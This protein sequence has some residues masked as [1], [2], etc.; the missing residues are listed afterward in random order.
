MDTLRY[1]LSTVL[2]VSVPPA[3][4]FWLVG[5]QLVALLRKLGLLMSYTLLGGVA[6]L[7]VLPLL[8]LRAVLVGADLGQSR[9]LAGLGVLLWIGSMYLE[10][11]CR[12]Y[13]TIKTLVGVPEFS[14]NPTN[15]PLIIEGIYGRMRHPRYASVMLG[16]FA[17]AFWANFV[18]PY[19]LAVL[20]VPMLYLVTL[21]EERE[22]VD[23]FGSAYVTYQGRVPRFIPNWR[24]RG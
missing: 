13:L 11:R 23:R 8:R 14:E 4:L 22:L 21:L 9:E 17:A 20:T 15:Q 6:L 2:V 16:V 1:L 7:S 5:H 18:G 12:K 3:I 19:I 24:S 10:V